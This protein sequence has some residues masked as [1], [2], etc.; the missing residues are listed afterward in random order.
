MHSLR[1]RELGEA[2]EASDLLLRICRLA[3]APLEHAAKENEIVE[4]RG[5]VL[6]EVELGFAEGPVEE[7]TVRILEVARDQLV[8]VA[9]LG[10]PLAAGVQLNAAALA[11]TDW[12]MR[13]SGSGT[14]QVLEAALGQLG[15]ANPRVA[16]ELPTNEAVCAAVAAGMGASAISASVAAAALEAELIAQAPLAL[17]DRAFNVLHHPERPLSAAAQALVAALRP[18]GC[19]EGP[20]AQADRR[21]R[22]RPPSW[23]AGGAIGAVLS[24]RWIGRL[25]GRVGTPASLRAGQHGLH[26]AQRR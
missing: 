3:D 7:G 26:S 9:P 12:V 11:A 21:E 18:R 20:D 24:D 13:E 25:E 1:P 17:P 19:G 5:D 4:T 16:L 10:H 8:L 23:F 14:R 2:V 22:P 6:D 15:V